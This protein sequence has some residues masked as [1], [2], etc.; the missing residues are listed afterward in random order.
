MQHHKYSLTELDNMMPWERE[1]YVD[2]LVEHIS[3]ENKKTEER[4]RS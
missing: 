1:I 4:N 2:M 3:E